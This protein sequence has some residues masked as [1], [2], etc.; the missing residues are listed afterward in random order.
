MK[1]K[2]PE[3]R[4]KI[5]NI[6]LRIIKKLFGRIKHKRELLVLLKHAQKNY[7]IGSDELLIIE[8]TLKISG[9][10]VREIMVPRAKLTVVQEN[11]ALEEFLPQIIKSAH[12]RFPVMN[13][14]GNVIGILLAKDL[15]PYVNQSNGDFNL[16]KILHP[17]IHIPESKR[18]DILLDEFRR[19][20]FHMAIV[21]DEFGLTAGLVT[22][23]DVLEEIVGEIEDEH[24]N[25]KS[26]G[27]QITKVPF[28]KSFYRVKADTN[29]EDFNN[30]FMTDIKN[31][32]AD[33]IGGILINELQRMPHKGDK[34]NIGNMEL[35]VVKQDKKRIEE[36]LVT[37]RK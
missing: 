5:N 8:G 26:K 12:S 33:S 27:F 3:P 15:L 18:L 34:I 4:L 2:P 1:N 25:V 36:L 29:L 9:M 17:A 28:S 31:K 19:K 21:Q 14:E 35:K 6:S 23:E 24:D 7:L 32:D 30:Y 22:I 10:H 37:V 11:Q 16:A 13:E 20:R